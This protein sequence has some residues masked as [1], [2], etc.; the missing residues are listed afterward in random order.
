MNKTIKL[1]GLALLACTFTLSSCKDEPVTSGDGNPSSTI[2]KGYVTSTGLDFDGDG[3]V[4]FRF[5]TG[6]DA[7]TYDAVAN[8]SLV[9]YDISMENNIVTLSSGYP[10]AGWDQI[11]NLS[12]DTPIDASTQYWGSEGDACLQNSEGINQIV[13]LKFKLADGIHYGWACAMHHGD[14]A[15]WCDIFYETTPNTGIK[16]GQQR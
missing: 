7:E 16:A 5:A 10:N 8:G 11:R 13:G 14:R 9:F 12:L 4:E 1:I 6:E 2:A 3:V 15:G